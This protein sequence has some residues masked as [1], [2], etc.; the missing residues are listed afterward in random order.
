ML[1][2]QEISR[3]G[4]APTS[5]DLADGECLMLRGPSGAGKSL[6]LRA[7]ADLDPN[8]GEAYLDGVARSDRSGPRWRREVAYVP[9]EPG[10]WSERLGDHFANWDDA[11]PL[12]EALKLPRDIAGKTVRLLS[13]GERQR[14]ALIRAL[15]LTPR[16]LLL[17]E[18]TAPLDEAATAAVERLARSFLED[19][20]SILWV[21][22]DQAQA[23]RMARRVLRIDEGVVREAAG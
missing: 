14:L 4:L 20:R 13:T 6:L 5:F 10:W 23:E 22:H 11:A 9:A 2:L 19:G 21:T 8:Q 3:P 15:V 16:V 17:D 18:P 7:I 1:S 12:L